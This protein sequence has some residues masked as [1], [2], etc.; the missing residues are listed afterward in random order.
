MGKPRWDEGYIGRRIRLRD[1]HVFSTVAQRGSMAKAAVELG[2]TQPAVSR[3]VGELEHALGAKLLDR[4]AQGAVATI[5]GAALLRHSQIVFDEVKQAAREIEFLANP[6]VGEVRIGCPEVISAVLTPTMELLFQRYP[7][8]VPIIGEV[9]NPAVDFS[10][11]RARKVDLVIA[12]LR[13]P[14]IRD[15]Q[16]DD[17]DVRV[18]FEDE[19]VVVAGAKSAWARRRKLELADLVE[20][21]WILAEPNTVNSA[22]IAEAFASQGLAMP[23]IRLMTLSLHLRTNFAA[24]GG[25][26]TVLPRSVFAVCSERFELREL[27]VKIPTPP[28]PIAVL[29]LKNR[30]PSPV[31]ALFIEHLFATWK[32]PPGKLRS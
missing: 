13:A 30:T 19:L 8:I 6:N 21:P 15:Q 7:G 1:L 5:Y 27:P 9:A 11:L 2:I 4:G 3:I 16:L 23:R 31:V 12:R 20:A 25:H 24:L 26:V 32:S 10:E 28:L 22:I 14:F 17:L 29:T 18:L